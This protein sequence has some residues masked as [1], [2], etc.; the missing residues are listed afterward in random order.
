MLKAILNMLKLQVNEIIAE[1]QAWFRARRSTTEQ[2][3]SF[4]VLYEKYWYLQ[5]Q[6]NQYHVFTDFKK[7]LTEYSIQPYEPPYGSTIS[8][9]I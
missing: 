7:P 3:F 1:E 8:E 4:K 2:I 5:H 6:Q 9:Q